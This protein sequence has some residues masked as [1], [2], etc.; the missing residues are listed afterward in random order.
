M[1]R[2]LLTFFLPFRRSPRWQFVFAL[3][4]AS[5]FFLPLAEWPFRLAG[6][7]AP[8][9]LS[10]IARVVPGGFFGQ[11]AAALIGVYFLLV[12]IATRLHD[13]GRTGFWVILWLL[14]FAFPVGAL[15][16]PSVPQENLPFPI[17]P[18]VMVG[19]ADNVTYIAA[20]VG[21]LWAWMLIACL[22]FP[23]THGRNW[24]GRDPSG[25]EVETV[26]KADKKAEK[27]DEVAAKA[28]A[29][30]AAKAAGLVVVDPAGSK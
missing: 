22:V 15:M 2:F 10:A 20:A 23:G 6:G 5:V 9:F 26:A 4:F 19:I 21:A 30:A 17:P 28:A 14:L 25:D 3:L 13:R 8:D 29:I 12:A 16:L 11:A 18:D 7:D 24:F 1:G 27:A